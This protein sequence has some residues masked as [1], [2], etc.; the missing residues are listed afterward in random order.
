MQRRLDGW[1]PVA[2]TVLLGPLRLNL[3]V[4]ELA[5]DVLVLLT[6]HAVDQVPLHAGF[7]RDKPNPVWCSLFACGVEGSLSLSLSTCSY[8]FT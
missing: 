2:G 7:V 3:S 1:G 6:A 5:L 4:V 8:A